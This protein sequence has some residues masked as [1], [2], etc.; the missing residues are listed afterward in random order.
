M[1]S[2]TES[3]LKRASGLLGF[4]S[5]DTAKALP[6]DGEIIFC[7]NNVCVH[8]PAILSK[9][10]EE[11]HPG[12]LS[13]RSQEDEVSLSYRS[14]RFIRFS[15]FNSQQNVLCM[16]IC[17]SRVRPGFT[18]VKICSASTLACYI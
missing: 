4:S 18:W 5:N 2:F 6:L 10:G 14:T 16:F 1:L 17:Y 13:I 7:K 11:H 9:Q 15:W 12:Y 3:L 8:P